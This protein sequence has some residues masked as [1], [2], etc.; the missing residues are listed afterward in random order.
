MPMG[1]KCLAQGSQLGSGFEAATYGF[2][3][4]SANHYTTTPTVV[5]MFSLVVLLDFYP[6]FSADQHYGKGVTAGGS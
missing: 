4:W 6:G 2:R 5:I 1:V 3:G